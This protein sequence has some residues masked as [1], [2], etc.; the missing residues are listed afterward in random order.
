VNPFQKLAA[1]P[2]GT[3]GGRG[4]Q[5]IV[6]AREAAVNQGAK[7]FAI[8]EARGEYAWITPIMAFTVR[9]LPALAAGIRLVEVRP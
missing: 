4:Y 3:R 1:L 6:A 2:S 8:I 7:T 5:T 9:A